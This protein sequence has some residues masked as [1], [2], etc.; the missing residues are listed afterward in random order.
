MLLAWREYIK[1][2]DPD[3]VTGYNICNF[4][5]NYLILRAEHLG[6]KDYAKFTRINGLI[7]KIKDAVSQSSALGNR[8]YKDMNTEGRI[9]FDMHTYALRELK[10]VQ[11]SLN[12]LSFEYLGQ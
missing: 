4:D 3:I 7:C 12:A 9:L 6:I 5:F 8:E 10:L 1:L 11:Y 2:S